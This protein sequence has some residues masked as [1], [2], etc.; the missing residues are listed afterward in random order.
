MSHHSSKSE[1]HSRSTKPA[2]N[3]TLPAALKNVPLLTS[4]EA[5]YHLKVTPHTLNVWRCT[6]RYPLPF[7][8]IGRCVRYRLDD[9]QQFI[10]QCR[11]TQQKQHE[12]DV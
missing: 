5:A 4:E 9:I 1:T 3:H 10:A 6:G 2:I 7:V 8:K 11:Y 12:D